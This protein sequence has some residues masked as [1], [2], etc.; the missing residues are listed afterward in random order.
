MRCYLLYL[1]AMF[2][3]AYVPRLASRV[4]A[5]ARGPRGGR[6]RAGVQ[7]CIRIDQ[8]PVYAS[9]FR[10]P[11]AGGGRPAGA[12]P[13]VQLG[14]PRDVKIAKVGKNHV[15]LV[16]LAPVGVVTGYRVSG[17]C[18]GE[19]FF[20]PLI[21]DTKDA[22]CAARVPVK[23]GCWWELRV[24]AISE[25]LHAGAE[26][27]LTQPVMTTGSGESR[28]QAQ[29]GE[30][31]GRRGSRRRRSSTRDSALAVEDEPLSDE[32]KKGA[33][34]PSAAGLKKA[35]YARVKREMRAWE[36]AFVQKHGQPPN[37]QQR[38]ASPRYRKA[39]ASYARLRDDIKAAQAARLV[40]VPPCLW[41]HASDA[42][43]PR[44]Y[45]CSSTKV[46]APGL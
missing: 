30:K 39:A 44:L 43:A 20:V 29:G 40:S 7:S 15:E 23:P 32:D 37:E 3:C 21:E 4:A 16:W 10:L 18:G 45:G 9:E 38:A 13:S 6:R 22:A 2:V 42:M 28:R 14:P 46:V 26:S 8:N 19:G 31:P 27:K 35:E 36:A 24:A 33:V 17:R 11:R 12:M 34:E 1:L 25:G 5:T 41:P